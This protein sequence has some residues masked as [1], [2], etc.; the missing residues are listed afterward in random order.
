MARKLYQTEFV[1]KNTRFYITD[2][3]NRNEFE[4]KYK[5]MWYLNDFDSWGRV[6]T[7]NSMRDL[8]K[9]AE[10]V[11]MQIKFKFYLNIS[12]LNRGSTNVKD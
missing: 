3:Y 4:G 8:Y 12:K 5:L 6:T 7:D 2:N 10:T 9:Y 11:A 1:I